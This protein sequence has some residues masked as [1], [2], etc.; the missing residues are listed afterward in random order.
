MP[1]EAGV[2]AAWEAVQAAEAP[3]RRDL[4]QARRNAPII[5]LGDRSPAAR[6]R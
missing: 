5:A 4:A 2:Q 1:L 3:G 6:Q